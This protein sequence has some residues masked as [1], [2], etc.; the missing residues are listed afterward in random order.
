M[1][2]G[3]TKLDIETQD[4]TKFKNPHVAPSVCLVHDLC[5]FHL[6]GLYVYTN[7]LVN[8]AAAYL[9]LAKLKSQN[10]HSVVTVSF[11]VISNYIYAYNKIILHTSMVCIKIKSVHR[12]YNYG[13]S[14]QLNYSEA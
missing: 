11:S 2:C 7:H 1:N 6:L 4:S 9:S 13:H 12:S 8:T 5:C 14:T 10:T 3:L